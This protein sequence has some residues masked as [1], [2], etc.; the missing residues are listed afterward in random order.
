MLLT[1]KWII[2]SRL[3]AIRIACHQHAVFFIFN[4]TC[5]KFV[6]LKGNTLTLSFQNYSSRRPSTLRNFSY[7]EIKMSH[8]R[9]RIVRGGSY[10]TKSLNFLH[11]LDITPSLPSL[12][13][14]QT[15][16]LKKKYLK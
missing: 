14:S 9:E 1:L 5:C 12:P 13:Q 7:G 15:K 16:Y 6:A 8:L 10:K 3:H 11:L 4:I 2:F